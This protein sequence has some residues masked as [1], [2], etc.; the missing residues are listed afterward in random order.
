MPRPVEDEL[1]VCV[2]LPACMAVAGSGLKICIWAFSSALFSPFSPPPQLTEHL[3]YESRDPGAGETVE[4]T[5]NKSHRLQ[6]IAFRCDNRYR[7]ES[8]H[9]VNFKHL[10]F[11]KD[12]VAASVAQGGEKTTAGVYMVGWVEAGFFEM[13]ICEVTS[14]SG[15]G[16]TCEHQ[17]A[18]CLQKLATESHRAAKITRR[19]E[20]QRREPGRGSES[21]GLDGDQVVPVFK[22]LGEVQFL[23]D[24]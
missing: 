3:A 21:S 20:N 8:R 2:L 18:K 15:D 5:T 19:R 1:Y 17:G 16:V 13:G 9:A 12:Q 23:L 14:T 10:R 24:V 7:K 6:R 11:F 22:A 4:N